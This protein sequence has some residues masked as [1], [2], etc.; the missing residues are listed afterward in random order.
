[1]QNAIV[2][3]VKN[4]VHVAS[5]IIGPINLVEHG[6]C[7]IAREND[8]C[9]GSRYCHYWCTVHNSKVRRCILQRWLSRCCAHPHRSRLLSTGH[10]VALTLIL[11]TRDART[12]NGPLKISTTY[13]SFFLFSPCRVTQCQIAFVFII[14]IIQLVAKIS[15]ILYLIFSSKM[16]KFN[17]E[18]ENVEIILFLPNSFN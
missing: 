4:V 9:S 2:K 15:T 3:I 17:I 14:L 16:R 7:G 6:L 10:L 18:V 1:M 12:V 5:V 13:V 8:S 11:M